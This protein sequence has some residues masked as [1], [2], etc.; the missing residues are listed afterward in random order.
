MARLKSTSKGGQSVKAR[1]DESKGKR[2][3][4]LEKI[5]KTDKMDYSNAPKAVQKK[6]KE[7]YKK[8]TKT[9]VK[10]KGKYI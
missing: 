9:K 3:A 2:K 10:N 5:S 1:A 7:E 4:E 8:T 6:I